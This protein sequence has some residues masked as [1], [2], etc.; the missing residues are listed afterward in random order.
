VFVELHVE[1]RRRLVDLGQPVAVGTS[2]LG[3]GRWRLNVSGQGNHAGTTLMADRR[4]PMV[5]AGAVIGAVR[6][7][8]RSQPEARAAVGRLVPIPG[9]TNAIASQVD[10]WLDARHPDDAITRAVVAAIAE[11]AMAIAADEGCVVR[12]TEESISPTVQFDARLR[13]RLALA[14]VRTIFSAWTAPVFTAAC[15]FLAGG[16]V[17][18]GPGHVLSHRLG[19]VVGVWV[20]GRAVTRPDQPRRRTG[21]THLRRVHDRSRPQAV[22]P[23]HRRARPSPAPRSEPEAGNVI[24][25]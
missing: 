21:S 16:E 3:H 10:L 18:G 19:R 20:A 1:Q 24:E 4:D 22:R 15:G 5:A 17:V 23:P 25:C 11:R 12:L 2:I 9:G 13:D 6:D 8:A 14:T 7:I